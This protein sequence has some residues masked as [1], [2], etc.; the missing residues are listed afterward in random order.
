MISNQIQYNEQDFFQIWHS[1]DCHDFVDQEKLYQCT[2]MFLWAIIY[3]LP[4]M[5]CLHLKTI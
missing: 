4:F 2:L 3:Q 5:E 1:F